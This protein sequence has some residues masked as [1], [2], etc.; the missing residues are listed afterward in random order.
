MRSLT[1]RNW[2]TD[3]SRSACNLGARTSRQRPACMHRVLWSSTAPSLQAFNSI[4][5]AH[6]MTAIA[7]SSGV[8]GWFNNIKI[9]AKILILSGV[10]LAIIGALSFTS[11]SGM[12]EIGHDVELFE[13][14]VEIGALANKLDREFV[15]I[16]RLVARFRDRHDEAA[17]GAANEGFKRADGLIAALQAKAMVPANKERVA[18]VHKASG[19]YHAA[20]KRLIDMKHE[21]AKLVATEIHALGGSM[22]DGFEALAT[23]AAQSGTRDIAT[24]ASALTIEVMEMRLAV[25]RSIGRDD[26]KLAKAAADAMQRVDRGLEGLDRATRES[27]HRPAFEKIAALTKRYEAGYKAVHALDEKIEAVG[28]NQIS[29]LATTVTT[30]LGEVVEVTS[31]LQDQAKARLD[32]DLAADKRIIVVGSAAALVLGLGIALLIGRPISRAVSE[33]TKAMGRLA[34]GDLDS[35]I[36]GVERGDEIGAMAKSVQVFRDSMVEAERL[37]T[38]AAA[39]TRK[40]EDRAKAVAGHI[41]EFEAASAAIVKSVSSA[42]SELQ[43]A[44]QSLTAT[45]EETSRQ[46]TAVAAA[47]EQ[48]STNVQTVAAAS[49]ELSSS[50]AEIARQVAE[51]TKSAAAGVDE[52]KATNE[53]VAGLTSAA[54]KIGDVVKLINDIASQTNLL[55]LNATIEAARA[56]EAGKGFAVVAAEVKNLA[57]QTAKATEEIGQQIASI[58]GATGE[59]AEAIQAIGKSIDR[60]SEISS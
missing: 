54:Q 2:F 43:T 11:W 51:S 35:A 33:M 39:E 44:A 9:Q 38:E 32:A 23:A 56:G 10:L 31:K 26:A 52:A 42:A 41:A 3:I 58:Q 29:V 37:R 18:V 25:N 45:A 57:N 14:R 8:F 30:R 4:P 17:I 59:S 34:A 19:E 36:P 5:E 7:R 53:K 48:A 28:G 60:M 49:E 55:A 6:I 50:I 15:D 21:E 20:F 27:P 13:E 46:S 12:T 22:R 16:R 1:D 40:R 24:L 47:S